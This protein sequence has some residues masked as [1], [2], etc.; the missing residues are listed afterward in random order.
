M[1]G[2]KGRSVLTLNGGVTDLFDLGLPINPLPLPDSFLSFSFFRLKCSSFISGK[3]L[4][5]YIIMS[6]ANEV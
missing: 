4:L 2:V 6:H 5:K 1:T 3:K